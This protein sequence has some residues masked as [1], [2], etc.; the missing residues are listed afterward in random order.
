MGLRLLPS[1]LGPYLHNKN[2]KHVTA[3]YMRNKT[4]LL[5][6]ENTIL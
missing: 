6:K 1:I 4:Y 2:D 3:K 5:L